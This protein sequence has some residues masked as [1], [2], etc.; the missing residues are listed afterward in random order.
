MTQ[1]IPVALAAI[2]IFLILL[3]IT[4]CVIRISK[5]ISEIRELLSSTPI[6][7]EFKN[8]KDIGDK[9][10]NIKEKPQR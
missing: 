7:D 3:W 6:S 8:S 5:E 10:N 9:E 4:L 2:T 1:G